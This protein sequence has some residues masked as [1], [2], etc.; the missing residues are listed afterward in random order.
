MLASALTGHVALFRDYTFWASAY[1][2]EPCHQHL[3]RHG[4]SYGL[5]RELLP[6]NI[7][8]PLCKLAA[9]LGMRP[10]MEYATSYA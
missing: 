8:V 4:D 3:L 7:A 1:L 5:G 2:L 6:R 10:F 9:R